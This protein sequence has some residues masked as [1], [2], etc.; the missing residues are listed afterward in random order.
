MTKQPEVKA[1]PYRDFTEMELRNNVLKDKVSFKIV[2]PL[3]PEFVKCKS[4]GTDKVIYDQTEIEQAFY[5]EF[6]DFV[7]KVYDALGDK[8]L[9]KEGGKIQND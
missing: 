4:C 5:D 9:I 8:V 2:V 3:N 7:D 6:N 1:Y